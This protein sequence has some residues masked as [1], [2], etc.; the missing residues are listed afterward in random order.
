M[1]INQFSLAKEGNN[2]VTEHFQVKE[3]ACHDGSDY[4]PIDID[5]AFKLEDIRQH[6]GKPITVTSGYRTESYNR[7]IGGTSSSYHCKG[8]AFDIVV[9]GVSPYDVAHYAQGLWINGIGC[10]YDDGFV[11]IDSRKE[12]YYWKNQ[13]V[14]KV[15]TFDNMPSCE[16]NVWNVRLTHMTD[17]WSFPQH[18]LTWDGS[19][20]EFRNVLKNSIVKPS[21]EYSNVVKIIQYTVGASVD[22]YFGNS[23]TEKIKTWQRIHG[24]TEDGIWGEQC[25]LEAL[26]MRKVEQPKPV[27]TPPIPQ[28]QPEPTVEEY[29]AGDALKALQAAVNIITNLTDEE[30]KKLDIDNDGKLTASDALKILQAAVGLT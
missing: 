14:T 21:K 23:T 30:K 17:G 9:K 6:F 12:P 29:T 19:D 15:S 8:R 24:L 11:H 3:F 4:V 13:S 1:A 18:G 7:S 28:P 16:C 25:W 2:K 22:G 20:E 27:P 26:G 5:L 10:Y